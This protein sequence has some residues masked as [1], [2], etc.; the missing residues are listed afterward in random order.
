MGLQLQRTALTTNTEPAALAS[1][2]LPRTDWVELLDIRCK[3]ILDGVHEL[4]DPLR[5]T[6][7]E[8]LLDFFRE[9]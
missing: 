9:T 2:M 5:V 6:G 1:R 7:Q 4:E 8:E 3:P